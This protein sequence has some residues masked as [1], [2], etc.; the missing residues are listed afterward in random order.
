MFLLWQRMQNLLS[1]VNWLRDED[2]EVLGWSIL[3]GRWLRWAAVG[4][5]FIH[6]E[7][8]DNYFFPR[9][10]PADSRLVKV[11]FQQRWVAR[12]VWIHSR[13]RALRAPCCWPIRGP[14]LVRI[15]YMVRII[16]LHN[17]E[18]QGFNH[19][20]GARDLCTNQVWPNIEVKKYLLFTC[21]CAESGGS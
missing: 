4:W 13:N 18:K 2:D 9:F 1:C 14:V 12:L 20:G 3:W 17:K 15:E 10:Q 5:H 19:C 21:P 16:N 6:T 11:L 7:C 8:V